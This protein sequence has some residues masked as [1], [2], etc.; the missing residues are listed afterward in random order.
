[1]KTKTQKATEV[2]EAAALITSNTGVVL[3]NFAG[4]TVED[5]RQLRRTLRETNARLFITKKRL[6]AVAMKQQGIDFDPKAYEGAVGAVFS[7]GGI[8]SVSAPVV[9]FF[10][11]RKLE[12]Q[13]VLGGVDLTTKA[14]VPQ[15]TVLFIGTLPSREV[16]LGQL[17]GMLSAP[18]RS[19]LFILQQKSQQTTA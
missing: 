7:P 6:L 15:A 14:L 10:K 11:E 4:L 19:F 3:T 9:K 18:V 17:L 12:K 2:A 13:K 16:L 5:T 8:E 1:M